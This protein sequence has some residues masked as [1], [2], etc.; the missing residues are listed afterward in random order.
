M[1]LVLGF[2]LGKL[3]GVAVIGMGTNDEST[4]NMMLIELVKQC[5]PSATFLVYFVAFT[6]NP[7]PPESLKRVQGF[8]DS[9]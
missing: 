7:L 1:E 8:L 2:G 5:W 4:I 3:D 6:L 9:F